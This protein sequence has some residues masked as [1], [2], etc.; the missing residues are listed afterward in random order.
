MNVSS[1]E[2]VI[3]R[4]STLQDFGLVTEFAVDDLILE[5]QG[6]DG[7]IYVDPMITN[8]VAQPLSGLPRQIGDG[9]DIFWQFDL[10][11]LTLEQM[12]NV[13]QP[14]ILGSTGLHFDVHDSI[15]IPDD[16]FVS[17]K[18]HIDGT[19]QDPH[20]DTLMVQTTARMIFYDDFETGDFSAWTS[21]TP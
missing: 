9:F 20:T 17:V 19:N 12:T 13:S 14:V 11:T 21:I 2:R 7:V 10:D 5:L 8:G 16:G 3:Y 15:S 6:P 18:T 1:V 4:W